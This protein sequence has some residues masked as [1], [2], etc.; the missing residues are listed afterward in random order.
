MSRFVDIH[1]M[2]NLNED[3]LLADL[4]STTPARTA[5]GRQ[6]TMIDVGAFFG[7]TC[8][9]FVTSNWRVLAI[10]PDPVKH[11][12]LRAVSTTPDFSVLTC[13]VADPASAG[14]TLS[15]YTSPESP[16]ISSL[17]PFR[18]T[19]S[20]ATQV[21]VRTLADVM[22]EHRITQVDY[23]KV[24]AEGYDLKVLQ[25]FPWHRFTSDHLP[26]AVMAEF[27]DAKTTKLNTTTHDLGCFLVQ[28]GYTVFISEWKPIVRYGITH[29][30]SRI[31]D[32]PCEL[33]NKNAWGNF[34]AVRTPELTHRLRELIARHEASAAVAA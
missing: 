7:G 17:L 5:T 6:R 11:E 12:K 31:T 29:T 34:I 25:G 4:F 26:L 8:K 27:E 24:D 32:Y 20:V 10:E 16:G 28:L 22:D 2:P 33:E 15:F 9:P 19:H 30:W 21:P 23:L 13:A 1:P 18:D 3:R 14:R